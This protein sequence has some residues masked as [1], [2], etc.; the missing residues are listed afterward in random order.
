MKGSHLVVLVYTD[1]K[2]PIPDGPAPGQATLAAGVVC[3]EVQ[4][5]EPS[6]PCLRTVSGSG[7]WAPVF[8]LVTLMYMQAWGLLGT[9]WGH[10]RRGRVQ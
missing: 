5:S 3:W 6:P 1:W 10:C 7:V 2:G 8:Q 4:A 9:P